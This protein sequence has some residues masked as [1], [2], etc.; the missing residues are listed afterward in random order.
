MTTVRERDL[1]TCMVYIRDMRAHAVINNVDPWAVRQALVLALEM[2]T[3][4]ALERGV[5]PEELR[6][7][8]TFIKKDVRAWLKKA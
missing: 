5:K 2:D 6:R 4:A 7:F 3:A 1:T 8:D